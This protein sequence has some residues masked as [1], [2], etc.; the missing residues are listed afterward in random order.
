MLAL[1]MMLATSKSQQLKAIGRLGLIPA[2]FNISEPIIFGLPLMLN[3]VFFVP[4]LFTSVL[5]GTIAFITMQ[6]GLIG[7][8]Y[9]MLSWQMPSVIGAFFS[10]MDWKA[11][12]LILILI[13]IDGLIYF[14]FF[15]MYERTMVKM[16]SG[17][18]AEA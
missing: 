4:F 15:K 9:A 1:A 3:P 8:S 14:P 16:E 10:T 6:I 17:E 18:E 2:F 5:N 13:V 11:P 7:R 12:V